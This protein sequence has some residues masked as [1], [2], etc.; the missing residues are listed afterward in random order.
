L[1]LAG[2]KNGNWLATKTG[3]NRKFENRKP[4]TAFSF[5]VLEAVNS[6]R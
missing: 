1:L 6:Y 2:L 3:K 4:I 5:G